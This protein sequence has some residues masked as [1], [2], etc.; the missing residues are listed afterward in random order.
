MRYTVGSVPYLNAK[1][2][3]RW[4]EDQ[5]DDSPV[6]VLYDIPSRL[7]AMLAIGEVQAILVSSIEALRQ[8]G[9]RVAEGVCI[10][11]RREVLSVRVFSKVPPEQIRSLALD[12]SSM[13]SNALA[14]IVLK[15]R[16]GV[17]PACEPLPPSLSQM[18]ADHDACVLI[19]DNGM[20]EQGEGLHIL[21]LGLEWYELTNLPFVWAV[22][23][24]DDGLTPELAQHLKC[25][26]RWGQ[27]NLA[28]V[29]A[30]A[31]A[32]TGLPPD[33]CA[34]YL[35]EIMRYPMYE[36][37]LNGLGEFG[38]LLTEHGLLDQTHFPT[39]VTSESRTF[40]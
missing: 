10:G 6:K 30:T 38:R 15:D 7:P 3:V 14:H 5:G 33:L 13:T 40:A 19:G 31:P 32:E 37:E 11:T 27:A 34:R 9:K 16:Y 26:E 28:R 12:Q 23:M 18:L 35:R 36:S 22:W 4:F 29:L 24:G 20:R 1:P 39:I 17:S 25:A 2:L 8:P 21:D